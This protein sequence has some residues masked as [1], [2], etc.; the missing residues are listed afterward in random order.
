VRRRQAPLY[1]HEIITIILANHTL[2][3]AYHEW[4]ERTLLAGGSK[5]VPENT[6]SNEQQDNLSLLCSRPPGENDGCET[7]TLKYLQWLEDLL[8]I[9]LTPSDHNYD[10]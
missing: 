8:I 6:D 4:A 3:I 9:L 1:H 10:L 2:G 5:Q 7:P